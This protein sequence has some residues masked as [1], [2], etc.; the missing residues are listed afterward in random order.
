MGVI[1]YRS[2]FWFLKG[3]GADKTRGIDG[4]EIWFDVFSVKASGKC[5]ETD[6]E[7]AC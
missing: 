2:P 3:P 4:V 6:K 1:S 5:N 7:D